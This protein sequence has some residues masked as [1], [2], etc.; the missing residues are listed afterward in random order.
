MRA[1]PRGPDPNRGQSLSRVERV[2]LRG[3]GPTRCR[4]RAVCGTATLAPCA[5]A[6]AA[7]ARAAPLPTARPPVGTNIAWLNVLPVGAL[8]TETTGKARPP[9][10]TDVEM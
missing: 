6:P 1:T 2:R 4:Y 5:A 10:S 7:V 3:T 8:A 9:A